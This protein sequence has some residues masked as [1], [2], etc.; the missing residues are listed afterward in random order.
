MV[1][2]AA[3][4][5]FDAEWYVDSVELVLCDG[6]DQ[7]RDSLDDLAE[8]EDGGVLQVGEVLRKLRDF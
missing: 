3:A 8:D 4:D 1:V 6:V 7:S 2:T 5:V